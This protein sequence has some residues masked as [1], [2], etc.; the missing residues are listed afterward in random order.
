MANEVINGSDLM[1]F[2]ASKS[3]AAATSCTLDLTMEAKE[4]TSK[5]SGCWKSAFG[6][7]LGFSMKSDN[8]FTVADY[9]DLVNAMIA[10]D[11]IE[12]QFST[13]SNKTDCSGVPMGGWTPETNLF[14]GKVLI[15][16]ISAT[17]SNGE[18]AT[19]SVSMEG[20]GALEA[21]A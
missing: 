6:G 11:P 14:K 13:A 20:V 2:K 10:R 15:T 19:Y 4:N 7:Q 17:A 3:L 16:N 12:F 1:L 18:A 21:V 8:L 9:T 5:D